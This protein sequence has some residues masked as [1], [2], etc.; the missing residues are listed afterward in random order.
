MF[1]GGRGIEPDLKVPALTFNVLR[2][3]IAEE[4][5]F[6]VRQAAAGQVGGLENLQIEKQKAG[7]S[8]QPGDYEINEHILSAFREF[9]S[10]DK[11][12]GLTAELLEK[13]LNFAKLRLRDEF[14]TAAYSTE[15][16]QQV[17]LE[18]DPQVL[19]AI[20]LLPDAKKLAENIKGNRQ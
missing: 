6:F 15:I 14:V 20:D 11:E 10:K 4:A 16:G 1:Y 7:H 2:Q 12:S 17:L 13:E 18:Q 5:F 9:I 8:L 3:R 19:K